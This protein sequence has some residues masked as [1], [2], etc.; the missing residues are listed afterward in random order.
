MAMIAAKIC[1]A[2]FASFKTDFSFSLIFAFFFFF[3]FSLC[4]FLILLRWYF[5]YI[6]MMICHADITLA[7][8]FA[9]RQRWYAFSRR[10]DIFRHYFPL[11]SVFAI[12][13]SICYWWYFHYLLRHYELPAILR[14][15]DIYY[16][17]TYYY[18][19]D[20]RYYATSA[21]RLLLYDTPYYCHAILRYDVAAMPWWWWDM[22]MA[23]WCYTLR[24]RR[25]QRYAD[26][27]LLI[28]DML[29]DDTWYSDTL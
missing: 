29:F 21:P 18:D 12:T 13:F 19:D 22:L 23:R 15:D 28:D 8:L 25:L 20:R 2:F 4:C 6:F 16:F 14:C 11:F 3:S 27:I 9:I 1:H 17:F 10:H 26:M 5:H 24:C 7:P